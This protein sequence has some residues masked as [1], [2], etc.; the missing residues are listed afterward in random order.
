[1]KMKRYQGPWK[2]T[3]SVQKYNITCRVMKKAKNKRK[4]PGSPVVKTQCFHYCDLGSIPG[5]GSE[6]PQPVQRRKR[7]KQSVLESIRSTHVLSQCRFP[8]G[9]LSSAP[10]PHHASPAWQVSPL[11]G[12]LSPYFTLKQFQIWG[13]RCWGRGWQN[14][15][16]LF[17]NMGSG[18][19]RTWLQIL[20]PPL[21]LGQVTQALSV[22]VFSSVTV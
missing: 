2:Q 11:P 14:L 10:A 13:R 20:A 19:R 1:M 9:L 15:S 5:W 18:G 21:D 7:K 22:L 17:M 12:S 16:W 6:I 4:L 8:G 3:W